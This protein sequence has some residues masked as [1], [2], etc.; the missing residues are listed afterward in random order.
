MNMGDLEIG[1]M[2]CLTKSVSIRPYWG[3]RGGTLNQKF[4]S[5][6]SNA[7]DATDAEDR[8]Q[9]KNNY[10][11][12][13]PRLGVNGEW[14]LSYGFS[15][16]GKGSGA[17]LYG[18]TQA[19]N[20]HQTVATIGADPVIERQYSDGF[21]Q[22]VPNMQLALGF[23]WQ[24]C[25]WCDKMFFK[26]SASWETNCWWDQFNIPYSA[27]NLIAPNPTV[28]SQPLTMEGLTLNCE[29]DF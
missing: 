26:M 7:I 6:F 4:R 18:K 10:W 21:Y 19:R 12:A 27:S 25:F 5:N 15:L 23:Q 13:G 28:G 24:T 11:G 29:W 14:H 16:L 1:R 17:L 22:L 2:V 9:G 8:F 3:A 20:A